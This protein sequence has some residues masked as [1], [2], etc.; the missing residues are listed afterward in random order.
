MSKKRKSDAVLNKATDKAADALN[1][2]DYQNS[3]NVTAQFN[4][5]IDK[6]SELASAKFNN[7]KK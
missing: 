2:V 7:K 1:G 6:A 5:S 3:D 4:A